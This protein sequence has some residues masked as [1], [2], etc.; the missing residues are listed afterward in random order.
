MFVYEFFKHGRVH[1]EQLRD[2]EESYDTESAPSGGD[3]LMGGGTSVNLSS[4]SLVSSSRPV[5][6]RD[7]LNKQEVRR[8]FTI[9]T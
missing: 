9:C 4:N 5:N 7:V 3:D 1:L 2:M 8:P 6:W